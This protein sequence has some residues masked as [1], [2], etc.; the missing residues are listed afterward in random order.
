MKLFPLCL[1]L[2]PSLA[3][4]HRGA[5]DFYGCHRNHKAGG[6]HCH[7]GPYQGRSWRSRE[8]G[9]KEIRSGKKSPP[10]SNWKTSRGGEKNFE[11]KVIRILDGDTI[12]VLKAGKRQRTGLG[13]AENA[14]VRVR[15]YGV[16]C[17]EKNQA[18][19]QK[20]KRFTSSRVSQQ[21]VRVEVRADDRDG[22]IV[23]EVIFPRRE[24]GGVPVQLS[25]NR[26]LV[27]E[28]L[29]WWYK[30]YARKDKELKRLEKEARR[31]KRGL[32]ADKKPLAPWK[33]R[34]KRRRPKRGP[35]PGKPGA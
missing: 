31:E 25:L 15:L 28:G 9:R 8:E 29:A 7:K 30:R 33:W 20:A 2:L 14:A 18:F 6:Y 5:F 1:L 35:Q 17:P 12:E 34:Q 23:G 22:L 21:W 11:G 26:E 16:D 32:W 4:A 3:E 19:G 27:R 24:K 13:P 10:R